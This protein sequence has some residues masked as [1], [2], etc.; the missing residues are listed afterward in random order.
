MV[1]KPITWPPEWRCRL[2]LPEPW[3]LRRLIQRPP[4]R[5]NLNGLNHT[6]SPCGT[7]GISS[8]FIA[9]SG[10]AQSSVKDLNLSSI[11]ARPP[12][13][14]APRRTKR[15]PVKRQ[16]TSY[17]SRQT[18]STTRQ[19]TK[20]LASRR[21]RLHYCEPVRDPG[22]GLHA[23]RG[24]GVPVGVSSPWP[25]LARAGPG[26]DDGAGGGRAGPGRDPGRR[27][28]LQGEGRAVRAFQ[29]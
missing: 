5:S 14:S 26:R 10:S 13:S 9:R 29:E 28:P 1:Q 2:T 24:V 18:A 7:Q 20:G 3:T 11:I 21:R 15:L 12:C 27:P 8:T 17:S 4:E 16:G 19:G 23:V 25:C 6:R 22:G